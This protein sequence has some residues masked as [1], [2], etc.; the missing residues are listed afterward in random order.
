MRLLRRLRTRSGQALIDEVSIGRR[1]NV[2]RGC[3]RWKCPLR[4]NAARESQLPSALS[5]RSIAPWKSDARSEGRRLPARRNRLPTGKRAQR[6]IAG[7]VTLL[8]GF[9]EA[10]GG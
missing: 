9:T 10:N 6:L 5:S 1:P 7:S 2:P 3:T 4:E 8:T